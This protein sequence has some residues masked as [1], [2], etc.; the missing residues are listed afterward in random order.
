MVC[1]IFKHEELILFLITQRKI[2]LNLP[3]S[4]LLLCVCNN[5]VYF[6]FS[7][8]AGYCPFK[9]FKKAQHIAFEREQW[10]YKQITMRILLLV[11][12]ILL[13]LKN[14]V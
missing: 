3:K 13:L 12:K 6:Y 11:L 5:P 2:K 9:V 4:K 10:F 14:P 8:N 7:I 1:L